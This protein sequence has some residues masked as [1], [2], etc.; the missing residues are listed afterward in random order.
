MVEKWMK[1]YIYTGIGDQE[2]ER[3]PAPVIQIIWLGK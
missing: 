3:L 2:Y 1:E